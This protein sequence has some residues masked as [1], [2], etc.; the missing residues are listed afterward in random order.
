MFA[1]YE[2]VQRPRTKSVYMSLRVIV[3]KRNIKIK[4]YF[5]YGGSCKIRR[6]YKNELK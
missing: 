2:V 3:E 1:H 5:L 4:I 6:A